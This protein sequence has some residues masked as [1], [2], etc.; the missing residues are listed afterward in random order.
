[1]SPELSGTY[2]HVAYWQYRIAGDRPV[3]GAQSPDPTRPGIGRRRCSSADLIQRMAAA[4]RFVL[5]SLQRRPQSTQKRSDQVLS[6]MQHLSMRRSLRS[7]SSSEGGHHNEHSGTLIHGESGARRHRS[8]DQRSGTG[9]DKRR[10]QPQRSSRRK[11][12]ANSRCRHQAPGVEAASPCECAGAQHS[13]R[14]TRRTHEQAA[15]LIQ[16]HRLT[17]SLRCRWQSPPMCWSLRKKGP[18]RFALP[19]SCGS[20]SCAVRI[21]SSR[22]M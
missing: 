2:A 13:A 6:F 21:T 10:C 7:V 1:M 22:T 20:T 11:C 14:T 18:R 15:P 12:V 9:C 8:S 5:F 16:A 4:R 19:T 3:E 17:D